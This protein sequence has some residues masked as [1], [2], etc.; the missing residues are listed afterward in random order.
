MI[1]DLIRQGCIAK[2]FP[3]AKKAEN[4]IRLAGRAI[5]RAKAE[6]NAGIYDGSFISAYTGMFH[7][8]RTLLFRDGYK[9]KNHFALYAYLS[10]V[11]YD[12]IDKKYINELNNFRTI[13]HKIIYG[14]DEVNIR[15][16]QE[17]EAHSAI[18]IAE[19]FLE[20]VK[21]IIMKE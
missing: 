1:E 5:G 13:R 9:E 17:T 2:Y 7:C 18:K 21:K 4:S 3:D 8:A 19:G 16:I 10:A 20:A 12:K 15:E 11:Y 6:Y 14:D